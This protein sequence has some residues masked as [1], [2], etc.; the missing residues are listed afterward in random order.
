[1]NRERGLKNKGHDD[2]TRE[3]S[4]QLGT[5][6]VSARRPTGSQPP[7]GACPPSMEGSIFAFITPVRRLSDTSDPIFQVDSRFGDILVNQAIVRVNQSKSNLV[8][9]AAEDRHAA[10][11]TP[12]CS[13]QLTA[14]SRFCLRQSATQEIHFTL[15][16]SNRTLVCKMQIP[17]QTAGSEKL[18]FQLGELQSAY[19]GPR[20]KIVEAP[21]L[22]PSR[23]LGTKTGKLWL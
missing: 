15:R 7:S 22:R 23:N 17:H 9:V 6:S 14:L 1:M 19:P 21:F 4:E 10:N 5:C 13:S 2:I 8:D 18:R 12:T 11:K 20:P 3:R 16:H